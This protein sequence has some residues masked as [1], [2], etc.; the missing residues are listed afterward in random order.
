MKQHQAL[1]REDRAAWRN[2]QMAEIQTDEKKKADEIQMAQ[3]EAANDQAKIQA[4][5]ELTL[6]ELELK[7]QYHASTRTN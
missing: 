6:K 2:L 5:K 3:T 1:D 4:E 7:G